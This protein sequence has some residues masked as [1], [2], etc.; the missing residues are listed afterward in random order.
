TKRKCCGHRAPLRFGWPAARGFRSSY[1]PPAPQGLVS[2]SRRNRSRRDSR[3]AGQA[4]F[5]CRRP[6]R[7]SSTNRPGRE[8]P[9]IRRLVSTAGSA[10]LDP[11]VTATIPRQRGRRCRRR[12]HLHRH[13]RRVH[14]CRPSRA[15]PRFG[16]CSASWAAMTAG[17]GSRAISS[18]TSRAAWSNSPDSARRR[19]SRIAAGA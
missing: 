7:T 1:V 18:W 14:R 16:R 8:E 15:S 4:S 2:R 17:L 6:P 13:D 9:T 10:M 3:A 5:R 11:S 12:A 19:L